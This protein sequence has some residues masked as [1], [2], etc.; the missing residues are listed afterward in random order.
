MCSN[1]AITQI[2]T[3]SFWR[4]QLEIDIS[5]CQLHDILP[6]EA[7]NLV[8]ETDEVIKIIKFWSLIDC[9]WSSTSNWQQLH[10]KLTC[11]PN[12]LVRELLLS[13]F[14]LMQVSNPAI[15]NPPLA[16]AHVTWNK[17]TI[18]LTWQLKRRLRLQHRQQSTYA[19]QATA[20]MSVKC[21][22]RT[23]TAS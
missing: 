5:D 7:Q 10:I 21:T 12:K 4:C 2:D 22:Q 13:P 1:C 15:H 18:K 19:A 20:K 17:S 11:T 23:T 14:C 3:H 8:Y 16:S 6:S 9:K